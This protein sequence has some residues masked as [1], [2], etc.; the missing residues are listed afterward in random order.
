MIKYIL[1]NFSSVIF[2]LKR[3]I[4]PEII[5]AKIAGIKKIPVASPKISG[6]FVA[7]LSLLKMKETIIL[8]IVTRGQK[9]LFFIDLEIVKI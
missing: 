6:I 7:E 4:I 3:R 2:F 5:N 8:T 9:Y 1:L